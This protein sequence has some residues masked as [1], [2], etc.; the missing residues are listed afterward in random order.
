MQQLRAAGANVNARS[1]EGNT[2]LINAVLES[3][4]PQMD[5]LIALQ[6]DVDWPDDS[7][8]SP[9]RVAI[10]NGFGLVVER[11]IDLDANVNAGDR[12]QITPLMA[13]ARLSQVGMMNSL[14]KAGADQFA[15]SMT[16]DNAVS[17]AIRGNARQA[18]TLLFGPLGLTSVVSAVSN[19][20]PI[21]AGD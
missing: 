2:S 1:P 3:D 8:F 15:K 20:P 10:E 19:E 18:Q 13:A 6:A 17:L 11:L 7:G 4:F 12:Y 21:L 9:L 16:G 5:A 14:I